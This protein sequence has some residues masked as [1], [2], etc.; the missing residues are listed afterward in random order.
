[1]EV[2]IRANRKVVEELRGDG[3]MCQALLEIMEPE[4]NK[5]R[6]LEIRKG[7]IMGTV[8]TLRELGQNDDEIEENLI[9]KYHL[10][11]EEAQSYL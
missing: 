1:M 2:S 8:D 10:S 9:K 11:R 3:T 4:I 5:I 7:K 6:E